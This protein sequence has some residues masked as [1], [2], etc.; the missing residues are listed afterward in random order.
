MSH[1]FEQLPSES[2]KAYA[3]F[4]EY[5][6]LGPQRSQEVAAANLRKCVGT[7]RRWA[8]SHAWVARARDYDAF[9]VE[10]ER[11][12]AVVA[13]KSKAVD[14]AKRQDKLKEAEWAAAEE[15]IELCRKLMRSCALKATLGD[16]AKLLDVAS[17]LARLATGMETDRKEVTGKDGGPVKVEVDVGPLIKRVYGTSPVRPDAAPAA[18]QAVSE[19]NVIDLEPVGAAASEAMPAVAVDEEQRTEKKPE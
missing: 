4:C 5:L 7:L 17:K 11:E 13:L 19:A 2:S 6:R 14:W 12:L 1:S 8:E 9:A 18:L 15:A 16:V 3:A 10:T